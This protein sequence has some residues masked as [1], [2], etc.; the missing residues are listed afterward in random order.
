MIDK[1][2]F[3]ER[4]GE[5]SSGETE[6]Q[7]KMWSAR[8]SSVTV[9]TTDNQTFHIGLWQLWLIM[10]FL[11]VCVLHKT[12]VFYKNGASSCPMFRWL[13]AET[14]PHWPAAIDRDPSLYEVACRS[15]CAHHFHH[16]IFGDLFI[17]PRSDHSLPMSLTH[18]L[19]HSL[20][21]LLKT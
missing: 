17:G 1:G 5:P 16:L 15:Y 13:R 21:T 14:I 11:I 18:S 7:V 9:A 2:N 19:T 20:T 10:A 3:P 4:K 6:V 8:L 12:G